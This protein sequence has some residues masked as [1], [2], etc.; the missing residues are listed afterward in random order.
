MKKMLEAKD[1]AEELGISLSHAYKII[2]NLNKD[3]KAGG[4][5]TVCGKIPRAFW[6]TRFFGSEAGKEQE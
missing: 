1:V 6:N 3:L 4:Y 2:R 5:I